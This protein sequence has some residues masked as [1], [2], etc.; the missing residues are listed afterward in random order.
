MHKYTPTA[1]LPALRAAICAATARD[2][3]LALVPDQVLVTNGAK[4]AVYTALLTLLDPGDEVLIPDPGWANYPAMLH[5]LNCS[6]TRYSLKSTL[7]F[8]PDVDELERGITRQTKAIVLNSPGNPVGNVLDRATLERVIAVAEEHDLWIVSDECYDE[9]VFE[10]EH[11]S[12]MAVGGHDRV[13]TA[14]SFSKSYAMTGWRLGYLVAPAPVAG[15]IAKMQEPVVANAC[16]VSQKAA[17]AALAGP[18][19]CVRQMRD[20][21]HSRLD[22]ATGL[23]DKASVAYVRPRGALYLFVDVSRAGDSM[24]FARQLLT[25]DGV[26]VVPGSAFG[27]GGEGFVRASLSVGT[28]TLLEGLGR[29]AARLHRDD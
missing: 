7:S 19:D 10:G 26:C 18:Q 15:E 2:S 23:L 1:G 6:H 4:H 9:L 24:T 14:F 28:E 12:V 17:E 27:P 20:A 21:Y 25:E 16:S 8:M 3:G 11:V 5:V 22:A 29:L 13:I